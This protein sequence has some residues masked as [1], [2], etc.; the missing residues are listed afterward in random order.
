MPYQLE[1]VYDME[2]N[3]TEVSVLDVYDIASE[4]GKEFEKMIDVYGTDAVTS[5]MPKVIN[6]LEHL[7]D[8]ATKDEREKNVVQELRARI[9]HLESDKVEKAEE[10]L[11]FEKVH[12][13]PSF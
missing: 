5:L 1:F 10:R 13:W 6:A 9:A 2:D 11:R 4:I 7:E 12:S 3:E 8:L